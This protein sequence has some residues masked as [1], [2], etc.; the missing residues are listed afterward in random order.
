LSSSGEATDNQVGTRIFT[1]RRSDE[2]AALDIDIQGTTNN[3]LNEHV[4]ARLEAAVNQHAD[5]VGAVTVRLA[6]VNGP[7][8]GVDQSCKVTVQLKP[9]GSII[10]EETSEDMYSAVSQ[11]ADRVKQAVGREIDRRKDRKRE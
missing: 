3:E 9:T 11:A 8:G 1:R 4:A 10:V 5:R 2:E 6:D 7:K